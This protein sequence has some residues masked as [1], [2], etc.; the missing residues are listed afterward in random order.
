MILNTKQ[1]LQRNRDNGKSQSKLILINH[2]ILLLK[3]ISPD[4]M[5]GQGY[6][7][8]KSVATNLL[9]ETGWIIP[10]T[11][12]EPSKMSTKVRKVFKACPPSED[13]PRPILLHI[14]EWLKSLTTNNQIGLKI[15]E[16]HPKNERVII[17]IHDSK[18]LERRL[19][20]GGHQGK[21]KT[22]LSLPFSY[23]PIQSTNQPVY[24]TP[25]TEIYGKTL[26]EQKQ[27]SRTPRTI[28]GKHVHPC[29][30]SFALIG[31]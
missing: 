20:D 30:L 3:E 16:C 17:Y 13:Q 8:S 23:W 19:L 14:K 15:H 25:K 27:S 21:T 22:G 5:S 31:G 24:H 10:V 26:I 4:D 6:M 18:D 9:H 29:S 11:R 12:D 1:S 7:S 28:C 2:L